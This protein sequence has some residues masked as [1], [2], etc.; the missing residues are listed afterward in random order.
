MTNQSE[1]QTSYQ[2][3]TQIFQNYQK[4]NFLKTTRVLDGVAESKPTNV[5]KVAVVEI[6]FYPHEQRQN[7]FFLVLGKK[8]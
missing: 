4:W 8:S 5:S 2:N 7:V 3:I 6:L 1:F